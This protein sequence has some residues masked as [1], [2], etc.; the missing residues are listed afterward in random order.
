VTAPPAGPIPWQGAEYP[1]RPWQAVALPIVVAA[2]KR[3]ERGIVSATMGAGKSYLQA[4]LCSVKL[5]SLGDMAIVLTAPRK[6]LVK[7]LSATVARRCGAGNVGVYYSDRKQPDRRIIVCCNNSLPALTLDLAARRRRVALII[8]DEAHSSEADTLRETT[9]MLDPVCLVGFTATPFRSVPTQTVSLFDRVL[10]RY[11]M[12]EAVAAGDLVDF[13][14]IRIV[15]EELPKPVDE[16][17][18]DM[19][20][21]HCDGFGPGLVSASNIADAEAYA[22]WLTGQGW[23]ALP[24][25]SKMSERQQDANLARLWAGDVRCLVHPALL[26][27]GVD[28]PA[29]R[30]L[31]HRR[32]VQAG[33]RFWQETGRPTRADNNPDPRLGPKTHAIILDP[34]LLLGRHGPMTIEALGKAIEEATEAE[35]AEPSA[36]RSRREPTEQEAVALDLLVAYLEDVHRRLTDAGIVGPSKYAPGGWQLADVSEK[37]VEAIKGASKLTRH[38]PGQ[39]RDPIKALVKVPWALN[40]GQAAMLLDVLFG[41]A[42][43]ARPQIDVEAGIYPS[44]VQWSPG[45]IRV[46]APDHETILAAGRGGRKAAPEGEET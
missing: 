9:P 7:Q 36:A 34:H 18:L 11:T 35:E 4:E 38:V 22:A 6:R 16:V 41:G 43:W 12:R 30:W 44:Q 19:M 28:F 40:R 23:A 15:G 24:I 29:L 33:V 42:R 32:K 10:V 37:Q 17:C 2:L 26:A 13:R 27:E 8:V 21:E 39:C 5:P 45:L 25:H 46:D 14:H 31:C 20:R 3:R 1:P